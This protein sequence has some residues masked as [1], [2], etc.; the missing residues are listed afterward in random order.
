MQNLSLERPVNHQGFSIKQVPQP[1]RFNTKFKVRYQI[2]SSHL[3]E[4]SP[5]D[6]TSHLIDKEDLMWFLD[7]II[8]RLN[9]KVIS[10][11]CFKIQL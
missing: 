10:I 9:S 7:H 1:L 8:T 11:Y 2:S 6:Y 5:T 3:K 4:K